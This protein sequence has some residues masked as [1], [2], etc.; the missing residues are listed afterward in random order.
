[1]RIAWAGWVRCSSAGGSSGA[2][3]G[4]EG[5]AAVLED[6]LAVRDEHA[7]D[8]QLQQRKEA[9]DHLQVMLLADP[10][11]RDLSS[12]PRLMT[13]SPRTRAEC[14]EIQ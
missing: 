3:R 7:L 5:S 4:R 9:F 12:G 8:R 6:G 14:S 1:M 11:P 13:T 10:G 2:Q